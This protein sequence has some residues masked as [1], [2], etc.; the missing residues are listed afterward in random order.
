MMSDRG[1]WLLR[2]NH[3]PLQTLA[4]PID[5]FFLFIIDI[6]HQLQTCDNVRIS[7]KVKIGRALIVSL[8]H[9]KVFCAFYLKNFLFE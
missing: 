5:G 7:W 6:D 9:F 8:A 3:V 4:L 1:N 2:I